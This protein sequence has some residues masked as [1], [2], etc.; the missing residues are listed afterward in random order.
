MKNGP[1]PELQFVH[2]YIMRHEQFT[3]ILLLLPLLIGCNEHEQ[4]VKS[5]DDDLKLSK[6][7]EYYNGGD[8]M[9]ASELLEEL[10]TLYRGSRKGKDVRYY[11]AYCYYGMKDYVMASY[12][13]DRFRKTFPNTKR[14][15]E[16]FYMSAYC[17]YLNSPEWSLDQS[18][19][20]KAVRKLQLYIDRYP[21]SEKV[22]S[23]SA[24]IS[25]LRGK[26]EKK[27]YKKSKLYLRTMHYRAAASSFENTLET[28]PDTRY[29]EEIFF[30]RFKAKHELAEK[31]ISGKK[32]ERLEDA[33]ASY[34]KF[35]EAFPES[36][37]QGKA[38]R[39]HEDSKDALKDIDP[40]VS[41][42]ETPTSTGS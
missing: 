41:T 24:L 1:L 3:L 22:D 33:I 8:Y 31:S 20:R 12:Y 39:L 37:Y 34:R 2:S 10:V 15:K 7:K 9:K 11:H 40:T 4:I 18:E 25:E 16:A 14:S 38:E 35:A 23:C 27:A 28:F 32:E 5:N 17:D 21:E 6:A 30:Y 36:K 29:R 26:L 19:T 13:F 42:E